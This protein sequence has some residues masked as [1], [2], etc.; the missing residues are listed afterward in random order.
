VT[1]KASASSSCKAQ[2]IAKGK[3]WSKDAFVDLG[4]QLLLAGFDMPWCTAAK[5][6]CYFYHFYFDTLWKV[7]KKCCALLML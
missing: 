6:L 1:I 5:L 3:S 2:A 4:M 7:M